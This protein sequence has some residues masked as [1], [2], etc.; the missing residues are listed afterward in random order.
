M[1]SIWASLPQRNVSSEAATIIMQS[2]ADSSLKQYKPHLQAWFELCTKWKV[3]LY[4]PPLNMVLDY[5]T[6]LYAKGLK[7][8]SINTAKSAISAIVE[9]S[10]S[11]GNQPLISRFMKGVF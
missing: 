5:L 7:Y 2:W 11:V 4:N 8:D 6:T 1:Q 3:D 10:N 9:L